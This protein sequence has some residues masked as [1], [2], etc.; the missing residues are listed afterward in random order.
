MAQAVVRSFPPDI[1][2]ARAHLAHRGV[3]PAPARDVEA[4]Q[5]GP[6]SKAL[7]FAAAPLGLFTRIGIA[8]GNPGGRRYAPSTGLSTSVALLAALAALAAI[9]L[10]W[11]MWRATLPLE[12]DLNEGWNAHFADVA[13][14]GGVLYGN[15]LT[16]NNYPPLS[17][18]VVG[19][20]SALTF[21][22]VYVGRL[23]SLAMTLMTAVA[24]GL[25]IR[26]LGGSRFGRVTGAL[27][28]LATMSRFFDLYVG[29]N[30]P[31]IVALAIMALALHWFLR[32]M[33]K[34]RWVEP[35]VICMAVAGFYKHDLLSIPVTAIVWLGLHDGRRAFRAAL[36][37]GAAVGVGFLICW[38]LF[39]PS[40]FHDLLTP[41]QA[42]FARAMGG[43]GR[44]QWIAPALVI[45]GVWAWYQ[46]DRAA[47]RFALLFMTAALLSYLLQKLGEGVDDNAQFELVV[48]AAIGLGCAID[49]FVIKWGDHEVR[50]DR[51]RSVV[52]LAL[53]ARLLFSL[54][55]AP[56]L[57]LVSPDFREALLRNVTVANA[58]I[59][60]VASI[61]G[62]VVCNIET[63]CRWAGKP[64]VYHPWSLA[65]L[66]Q[67]EV[68]RRL[69]ALHVKLVVIDKR[70]MV[71]T[72]R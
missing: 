63:I 56:Y 3:D 15:E 9:Y 21:D 25:C 60:R 22:A 46:R 39:G 66:T 31:H 12:I 27:W 67:A 48:A 52:L 6:F 26:E 44:L 58:E 53:I 23:L 29:M 45:A 24:V 20:L 41:R 35:A 69:R 5:M 30:D 49:T 55:M 16:S 13:R 1:G 71:P 42:S 11:P 34:G 70:A 37:G 32:S 8:D 18:Y 51:T 62:S 4:V 50:I 40:F 7:N 61:P 54:R 28:F 2:D 72:F 36:V 59:S 33:N 10:A 43:L 65:R 68:D 57:V 14:T 64:F 47:A 17:F 19:F 38:A